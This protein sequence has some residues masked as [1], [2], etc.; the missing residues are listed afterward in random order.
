MNSFSTKNFQFVDYRE[1]DESMSRKVWECRN[2]PE[3]RKW[4]VN[5]EPIPYTSHI[6]FVNELRSKVNTKYY[7]IL[8][9]G[10]FVGSIN[11]HIE[12]DGSA[13]RGIYIHPGYWGNGLAKGVCREFYSYVL[14]NMGISSIITKVLKDNAGSNSLERSL[15]AIE[16]SEDKRFVYYN[17]DLSNY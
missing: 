15:G 7:A 12:E 5:P 13:E 9:D 11:L 6:H 16:S 17:C 4:M 2:L 1:M 3:I 8:H 10:V 14:N